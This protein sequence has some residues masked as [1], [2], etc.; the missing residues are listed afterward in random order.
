MYNTQLASMVKGSNHTQKDTTVN[1]VKQSRTY[2]K[3]KKIVGNRDLNRLHK[4]RLKSSIE[5]CDLLFANPILVN[6]EFEIID[7]QHRFEICVEL[8][9]PIYY[10]QCEKL[11]LKD[12]QILNANAK[13]WKA[14]D[15]I[16]G[17]CDLNLPEYIWL[18][19]FCNRYALSAEIGAI[20]SNGSSNN[21]E[22]IKNGKF[23]ASN[24]MNAENLAM[25]LN[26]YFEYYNGSYRRRFVE[27][28]VSLEKIKGFS[29]DKL[30][31]KLKYQRT[32]LCDC[33]N[34]KSYLVLL[35]EIYNYK[36]RG[37]KLRFF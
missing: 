20:I 17:Y 12:I 19:N 8:N 34:S 31:S 22:L 6:D 1:T 25:Y 7:G 15:Y 18:R 32:K 9:K 16:N 33:T 13:N 37:E 23:A 29:H 30:L 4:K 35:E 24:K 5:D 26:R 11:S 27:A 10:I 21:S 28:M 2:S 36:E 14:E 3:F